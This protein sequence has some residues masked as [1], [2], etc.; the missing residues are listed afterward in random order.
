MKYNFCT[1]F[2]SAYLSRGLVLYNSLREH[3]T[4]FHLYVFAF[5]EET[6]HYFKDKNLPD[7]TVISLLD[8]EDSQLL[9]VKSSR[10]NAEYCWTCTASTILYSIEKFTLDSCTYIDADMCFYADP[11]I[12]F[13][14][15]GNSSVMI[16]EHNYSPEYDQSLI[17]GKYCVQFVA[18]R[19]DSHGM[20]VLRDWRQDTIKWC[21]ARVEEGKFGDQK[22]LDHWQQRYTRVHVLKNQGGGLAPWN[23]QKFKLNNKGKD[24]YITEK[25]TGVEFSLVFFH[26]HGMRFYKNDIV[27]LTGTLYEMEEEIKEKLFIPYLKKILATGESLKQDVPALNFHGING[28]SPKKPLNFILAIAYYLNDLRHSLKNINGRQL[29]KR[30]LHHHYYYWRTII[31]H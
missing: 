23:M 9:E 29:R 13:E 25:R 5:D 22:Y 19:N 14:E 3:C 28:V 15:W 27:L 8:F 31:N 4:S 10:S 20:Q 18:F 1:L 24:F 7:L 6:L 26:F 11:A 30:Y 17:S 12:L 16:T 2:N 21:F